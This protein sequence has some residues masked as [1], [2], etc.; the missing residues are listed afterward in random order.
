MAA[1]RLLC[2]SEKTGEVTLLAPGLF[3]TQP[4]LLSLAELGG[5][6]SL[7]MKVRTP[8]FSL[9]LKKMARKRPTKGAT[10]G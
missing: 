1:R 10:S 8:P 3:Q 2:L 4:L 6:Q 5:L 9:F 7:T